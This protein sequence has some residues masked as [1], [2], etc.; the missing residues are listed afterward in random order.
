[1]RHLLCSKASSGPYCLE[2]EIPIFMVLKVLAIL[3]YLFFFSYS[4]TSSLPLRFMYKIIFCLAKRDRNRHS[5]SCLWTSAASNTPP[6]S[7]FPGCCCET[8]FTFP[9]SRSILRMPRIEGESHWDNY[10][11]FSILPNYAPV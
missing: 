5:L 11:C 2:N 4:S 8:E 3:G 7:S 10:I 9:P 6:A 1:M